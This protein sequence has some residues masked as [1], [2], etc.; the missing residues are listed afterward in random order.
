MTV[1]IPDR[2]AAAND[3]ELCPRRTRWQQ[4][5]FSKA[6][7][8]NDYASRCFVAAR[9][10]SLALNVTSIKLSYNSVDH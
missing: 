9:G 1:L 10:Y 8:T 7:R 2:I 6:S 5:L 4:L 3:I